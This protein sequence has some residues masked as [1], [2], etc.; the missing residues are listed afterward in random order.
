MFITYFTITYTHDNILNVIWIF[1][2]IS[3]FFG[4]VNIRTII[5]TSFPFRIK[6]KKNRKTRPCASSFLRTNPI[7]FFI[8]F[9]SSIRAQNVIHWV[10]VMCIFRT[11]TFTIF[12]VL[13][14][15]PNLQCVSVER[16][17]PVGLVSN[18]FYYKY[19]YF[20]FFHPGKIPGGSNI[21]E[22]ICSE[23]AVFGSLQYS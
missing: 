7:L 19:K 13:K 2:Y 23:C 4:W 3:N 1:K 21:C 5:T 18:G 8:Y 10:R 14:R 9:F 6:K 11:I 16:C 22:N 12:R 20:F 15:T 17:R